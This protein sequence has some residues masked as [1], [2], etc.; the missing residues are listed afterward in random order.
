MPVTQSAYEAVLLKGLR[1]GKIKDRELRVLL[2]FLRHRASEMTNVQFIDELV[3]R[4]P[5][6][7]QEVTKYD[8][9]RVAVELFD[10]SDIEAVSSSITIYLAGNSV[11]VEKGAS[12]NFVPAAVLMFPCPLQF[13]NWAVEA[14]AH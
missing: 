14:S 2:G 10:F 3:Q 7:E 1:A 8:D 6:V 5:Q 4:S 9:P 11:T 12:G 13:E